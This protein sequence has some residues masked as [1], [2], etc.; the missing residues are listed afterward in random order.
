MFLS[1]KVANEKI[2]FQLDYLL[3]KKIF[4]AIILPSST[5][6]IENDLK[7]LIPH[8]NFKILF[9]KQVH[10]D[11]IIIPEKKMEEV[12][13]GIITSKVNLLIGVKGADCYPLLLVDVKRDIFG[14]IHCGWRGVAS[15]IVEKAIEVMVGEFKSIPQ[16]IYAMVG[17]GICE[18]CYEVGEEL[19]KPFNRRF[20]LK[21]IFTRVENKYYLNLRKAINIKLKET[22]I[23]EENIQ[24]LSLCTKCSYSF[25]PSHRRNKTNKRIF[26]FIGKLNK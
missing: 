13:D 2:I 9:L 15:G 5:R 6:D 14:A 24:N 12:G 16:N 25:F 26:S 1:K 3:Q 4:N 19:L 17:I 18:A 20:S 23:P 10:S 22:K 7:K 8:N 21:E 11:K